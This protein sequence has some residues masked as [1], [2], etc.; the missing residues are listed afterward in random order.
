LRLVRSYPLSFYV[1][2]V[3][4]RIASALSAPARSRLLWL[5]VHLSVIAAATLAIARGW[6]PWP[7]VPALSLLI[8]CSFGGLMFLGHE[9]MHGAVVRGRWAWA[10]PIVGA[11]CFAPLVVTPR[12]WSVWH[13]RTHHGNANRLGVDPDMYPSLDAYRASGATRFATDHFAPGGG[14]WRGLFTLLV[15]FSGQSLQV[16]LSARSSLQLSARDHARLLIGAALLAGAWLALA[17]AIGP[18]AFLFAYA[19]PVVVAN[20]IVMAFIVTNHALSP[21]TDINDPLLGS[22]SVTVPR[23]VDWLTLD[24]GY[25]VEHHL[26]PA[27]SARH[28]RAIRA[29]L[30]EAWPERYQSLPLGAALVRLFRTGRVYQDAATLVDP[31]GGGAWPALAPPPEPP[32]PAV[33]AA[34]PPGDSPI[35]RESA[36]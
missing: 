4:P 36:A 21:A 7:L 27:A 12:L 3:R 23:W 2:H 1:R 13:N 24:F 34:S 8:G 17:A 11:L 18:L 5:P 20:V 35:H 25:H 19:L 22:L 6:L 15:G 31:R 16:L 33:A 32:S 29:A 9:T 26:F 30:V 28:G 10:K 14:R